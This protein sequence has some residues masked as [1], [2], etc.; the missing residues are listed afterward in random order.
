MIIHWTILSF[1]IEWNLVMDA[2]SK[3]DCE[4]KEKQLDDC[5]PFHRP[6][7]LC[8]LQLSSKLE[9]KKNHRKLFSIP[10]TLKSF[11]FEDFSSLA[12]LLWMKIN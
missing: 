4:K 7:L 12:P 3:Q 10:Q 5:D 11:A 6:H 2:T 9:E 1:Q 8:S